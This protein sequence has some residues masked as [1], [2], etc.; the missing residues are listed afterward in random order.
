M[1]EAMRSLPARTWALVLLLCAAASGCSLFMRSIEKPKA[2][3]RDVSLSAAGLGGVSGQLELDVTNPNGFGVPLAGIDWQLSLGGARAVTGTVQLSQTIPAR[4]VAPV[5]TSLTVEAR[6]A[7]AVASALAGGARSY[8]VKA[9]L[10]FT[11]PVGE[12]HV[13]VE[14]AGTLGGSGGLGAAARGVLGLR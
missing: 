4:G 7:I 5:A 6:D 1:H 9:R 3:V 2:S 10:R 13:D 12:V 14:H 8:T 11:T